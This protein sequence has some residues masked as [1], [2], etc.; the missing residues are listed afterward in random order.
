MSLFENDPNEEKLI[1]ILVDYR[2]RNEQLLLALRNAGNTEINIGQLPVGDYLL[3]NLLVE[4]KSF[5]DLCASIKDGRLFRQAAQLASSP[6]RSMVILEGTSSD[7][8]AI[9]MSR[10]AIQG[11]L[12]TISVLFGI[13]LIRSHSPE[14]TAHLLL[15]VTKQIQNCGSEYTIYPRPFPGKK[16]VRRK[17]KIQSHILQGFPGIGP[18]R[19]K[20]L[21]DKFGTLMAIFNASG[22]DL[23]EVP[24][25]GNNSIKKI[26]NLLN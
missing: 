15:Y 5:F 25:L 19:A 26:F 9:G 20:L 21:L 4:R 8:K 11:A 6:I 10:K 13:P 1:R 16:T 7:M 24:G 18:K 14:E 12:I 22:K 2:E 23:A 17:Q 3:E